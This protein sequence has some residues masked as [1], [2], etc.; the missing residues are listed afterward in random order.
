MTV[1]H[2]DTVHTLAGQYVWTLP[3]IGYSLNVNNVQPFDSFTLTR[4]TFSSPFFCNTQHRQLHVILIFI[5]KNLT[6]KNFSQQC[7]KNKLCVITLF[8]KAKKDHNIFATI[9]ALFFNLIFV[10]TK[11]QGV[12]HRL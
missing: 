10:L 9:V 3:V 12:R 1:T 11:Q 6:K 2:S 8:I 4:L 7:I 5:L